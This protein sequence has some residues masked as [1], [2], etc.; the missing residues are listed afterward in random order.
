MKCRIALY[1]CLTIWLLAS[2]ASCAM[3]ETDRSDCP[4]GHYITFKYDYNIQRSDMFNDHVGGVTVYVFDENDCFVAEHS[5]EN[6]SAT[7]VYPL[8]KM[9]YNLRIVWTDDK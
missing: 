7:G 2:M 1:N 4:T 5:E 9:G 3:M 8:K 6:I